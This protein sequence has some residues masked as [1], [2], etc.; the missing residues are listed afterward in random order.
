MIDISSCLLIVDENF[1]LKE[2]LKLEIAEKKIEQIECMTISLDEN[3]QE[4][5]NCLLLNKD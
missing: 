3:N 5:V 2:K 4:L 1:Q